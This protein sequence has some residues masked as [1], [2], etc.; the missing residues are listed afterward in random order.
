MKEPGGNEINMTL[1]EAAAGRLLLFYME[2]R[3]QDEGT[4]WERRNPP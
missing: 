1:G 3:K 4:K 2:G